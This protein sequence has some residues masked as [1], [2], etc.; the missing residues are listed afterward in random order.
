[1]ELAPLGID[2]IASAPGPTQSGFDERAGFQMSMSMKAGEVAKETL[3]A[4]GRKSTVLPGFLSKLLVYAKAPL[5]RWVRVRIM[6]SVMKG[7]MKH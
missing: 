1:L 3:N 6:G 7:A 5:P 2:V 4:L